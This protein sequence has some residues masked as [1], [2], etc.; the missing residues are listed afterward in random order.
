V[1]TTASIASVLADF[2][3]QIT[4]VGY[5]AVSRTS[6]ASQSLVRFESTPEAGSPSVL[7]LS[8]ARLPWASQIDASFDVIVR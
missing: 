4:A 7:I 3:S 2:E 6:D 5:K 8:L 1:N